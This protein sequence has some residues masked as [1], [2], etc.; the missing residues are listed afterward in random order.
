MPKSPPAVADA[1]SLLRR[2]LRRRLRPPQAEVATKAGRRYGDGASS[3]PS[4]KR[5]R[6]GR[7]AKLERAKRKVQSLRLMKKLQT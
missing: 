1:P 5:L 3:L 7:S 2:V 6:A 4:P